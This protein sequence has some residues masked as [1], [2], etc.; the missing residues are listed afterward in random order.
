MFKT[1]IIPC[2]DVKQGRVVKGINFIDLVDAGD[3]VEQA[4]FYSENGADEICFL[5]ID[6]SLENRSAM[7]SVVEKTASEVFIP[8]TVGGGIKSLE[9]LIDLLKAGAD[10]FSI[11]T[12]GI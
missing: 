1:R 3:P 6:A 7:L 2:L 4:K 5:D 11:N 10:N 12:S 9:D 8:F